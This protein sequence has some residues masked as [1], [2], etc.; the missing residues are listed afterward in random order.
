ML[1]LN[2]KTPFESPTNFQK[3]FMTRQ[4]NHCVRIL[5]NW[6]IRWN[7]FRLAVMFTCAL[8]REAQQTDFQL[9]TFQNIVHRTELKIDK[10]WLIMVSETITSHNKTT[11]WTVHRETGTIIT[12]VLLWSYRSRLFWFK[13]CRT[14]TENIWNS[15]LWHRCQTFPSVNYAAFWISKLCCK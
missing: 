3:S 10:D 14:G 6:S 9:D 2:C 12:L 4:Q 1:T 15:K 5:T 11:L 8:Q 7:G 13:Q